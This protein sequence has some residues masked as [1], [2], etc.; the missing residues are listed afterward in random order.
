[1]ESFFEYIKNNCKWL[2]SGTGTSIV[3]AFIGRF[4]RTEEKKSDKK[5]ERSIT[6]SNI[7]SGDYL[8]DNNVFG[9]NNII[10]NYYDKEDESQR[11]EKDLSFF[12]KR[13]QVLQKLLNDARAYDE[14]EFTVEYISNLIGFNNVGE[15]K[16]YIYGNEEPNDAVKQKFV[17]VFGVNREWMLYNQGEYPFASNL[18]KYSSGAMISGNYAMDILTKE[19]LV[20]IKEF[21]IVIGSYEGRRQALIIRHTFKHC[22]EVYPKVY[23]L[24]MPIGETGRSQLIS[25]YRF[26]KVADEI[27][28]LSSL[29]YK[30]TEE[31]FLALYK[32]S[33]APMILRNYKIYRNFTS[34]FLDLSE[35]GFERDKKRNEESLIEVKRSIQLKIAE[36]DKI[37]RESDMKQIRKNLCINENDIINNPYSDFI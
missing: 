32:G 24:D 29:V 7:I 1:M 4:F 33:V 19:N 17:E 14:K 31:E 26:L 18:K 10:N 16:K 8:G 3:N 15:M 21:I 5:E 37:N 23:N 22:Y 2:F 36:E 9:N 11:S 20:E 6:N 34:D 30:A 25:F 35:S 13:F 12:S 27:K 28:K